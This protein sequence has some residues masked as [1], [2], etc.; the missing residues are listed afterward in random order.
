MNDQR[1]IFVLNFGK[2]FKENLFTNAV[3]KNWP[4]CFNSPTHHINVYINIHDTKSVLIVYNRSFVVNVSIRHM[5]M[6]I[7]LFLS[8]GR[9]LIK[10]KL[11]TALL[12]SILVQKKKSL[13]AI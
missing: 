7:E 12:I 11:T 6:F 1:K 9:P 8:R 5:K 10:T 2:Q 3:E 4:I 13:Y